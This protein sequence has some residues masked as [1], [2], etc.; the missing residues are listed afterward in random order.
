MRGTCWA[1]RASSSRST[2]PPAD[3]AQVGYL[4]DVLPGGRFVLGCGTRVPVRGGGSHELPGLPAS[5]ALSVLAAGLG[6]ALTREELPAARNLAAAVDGQPLHLKQAAA[7]ARTGAHSL[8]ALAAQ[9]ADDPGTLD[10]L[11]ISSL[12]ARERRALAVLAFAAGAL[13]AGRARGRDRPGR[14]ARRLPDRPAPEGAGRAAARPVRP[15][16]VQGRELPRAAARRLP[17]RRRGG[18]AGPLPS[19]P[20]PVGQRIAV[21]RRRGAGHLGVHRRTAGMGHRPA[22]RARRRAGCVHR[23]A[24]GSVA[25]RAEPGPGRRQRDAARQRLQAYFSHQ[26]G[27]LELCLD[28]LDDA[29]AAASAGPGPAR[30]GGRPGRGRRHPAEPGAARVRAAASAAPAGSP[31]AAPAAPAAPCPGYGSR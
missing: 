29:A 7:L 28:R 12:T 27:S 20:A 23:R 4:L 30:A 9:A 3:P 18:G 31:A 17:G 11:S 21:G 14:P 1:R 15:A 25:P 26:L 5:A 8:A 22:A 2:T 19:D 6:R 16:R 24:V 10:R 13:R